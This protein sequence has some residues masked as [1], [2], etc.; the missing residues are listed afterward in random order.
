MTDGMGTPY[1]MLGVQEYYPDIS[2]DTQYQYY[3]PPAQYPPMDYPQP[4]MGYQYDYIKPQMTPAAPPQN[5]NTFQ[6]EFDKAQEILLEPMEQGDGQME[7]PAGQLWPMEQ[8]KLQPFIPY[9]GGNNNNN[10]NHF[11]QPSQN[12]SPW[13]QPLDPV[14]LRVELRTPAVDRAQEEVDKEIDVHV[15]KEQERVKAKGYSAKCLANKKTALLT[16]SE[17]AENL[18][19]EAGILDA[20]IKLSHNNLEFAVEYVLIPCLGDNNSNIDFTAFNRIEDQ[21]EAIIEQ[22]NQE[23]QEDE[24]YQE[25]V[26]KLRTTKNDL[27]QFEFDQKHKDTIPVW[28]DDNKGRR[29][30]SNTTL[31]TRI[32]RKKIELKTCQFDYEAAV[33]KY[34]IKR[35]ER[36]KQLL[37]NY[38]TNF[39]PY[40]RPILQNP[41]PELW[42]RLEWQ[43]KTEQFCYLQQIFNPG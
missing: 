39:N 11:I 27:A 41:P 26:T 4:Q 14:D 2:M 6:Y 13:G 19:D 25:K 23:K 33:Q 43:M 38:W 12:L 34:K 42:Q 8:E 10:N 15:K 7:Y 16:N 5:Q 29:I 20:E 28:V 30:A 40:L 22:I 32:S 21:K 35:L 18:K 37:D 36:I 17:I 3:S 1:G 9:T 31:A 24:K